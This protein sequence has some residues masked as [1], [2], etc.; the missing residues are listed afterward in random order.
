MS[1]IEQAYKQSQDFN[2]FLARYLDYY[3]EILGQLR[4]QDFT[5]V[6]EALL[7]AHQQDKKIIIMGNGGSAAN[8]NHLSTGLSYITRTWE[9]PLRSISLSNDALLITSLANDFSFAD[10]FY[11]QLQVHLQPGDVVIALSV[12]GQS[13]NVL[14]GL[15]YAR[16]KGNTCLGLTGRDG[17]QLK[18]LV[19]HVVH[20][21]T[22]QALFGVTEDIH[23]VLGHALTYYLEYALK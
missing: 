13:A 20:I 18:A 15:E 23:M 7:E 21:K 8:A 19:N 6:L 16:S 1:V 22:P 14:K 11:R 2:G 5:P 9:R 4:E 10:I 17:G 3:T 12:S